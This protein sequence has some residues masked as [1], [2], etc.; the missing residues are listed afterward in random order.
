MEKEGFECP[1][2][3]F[4]LL[5]YRRWWWLTSK[6]LALIFYLCLRSIVSSVWCISTGSLIMSTIIRVLMTTQEK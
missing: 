5:S 4:L 2:R 1:F 3:T 6:E